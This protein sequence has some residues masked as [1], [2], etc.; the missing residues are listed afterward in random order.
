M[1]ISLEKKFSIHQIKPGFHCARHMQKN[2]IKRARKEQKSQIGTLKLIR[3][4]IHDPAY[5]AKL[6]NGLQV[7]QNFGQALLKYGLGVALS[8]QLYQGL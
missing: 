4:Y 8:V 2:R 7:F 5:C 6:W 1:I 3:I